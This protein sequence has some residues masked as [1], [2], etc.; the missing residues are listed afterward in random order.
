MDALARDDVLAAAGQILGMRR[1][2]HPIPMELAAQFCSTGLRVG[3]L[4]EV[5]PVLPL[6]GL[7]PEEF[8][9]LLKIC[10]AHDQD[11]TARFLQLYEC[12]IVHQDRLLSA[13]APVQR[14]ADDHLVDWLSRRVVAQVDRMARAH[15][16]LLSRV[17]F[18]SWAAVSRQDVSDIETCTY[19]EPIL[20]IPDMESCACPA[21]SNDPFCIVGEDSRKGSSATASTTDS[22]VASDKHNLKVE[23]ITH[24]IVVVVFLTTFD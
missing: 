10:Q 24:C 7:G 8:L 15:G 14:P 12:C 18:L 5:L 4:Q 17:C 16:Q 19:P 20:S 22:K 6:L 23:T 21:P 2:G 3:R 1:D 13:R 9:V 11:P